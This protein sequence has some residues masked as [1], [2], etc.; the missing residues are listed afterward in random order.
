MAG[1]NVQ[2][3]F[4]RVANIQSVAVTAGNTSSEGGGTV[5]TSIFLA[6]TPGSNDSYVDFMRWM[7][8]ASAAAT[9]TTATV[10]RIFLSTVSTGTT[11][12]ANTFLIGEVP[13]PQVSAD[14]SSVANNAVDFALGFRIPGSLAT[15]PMFLM[16]TNH[17]APAATTQWLATTF[18]ADY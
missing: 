18:G 11:T 9:N 8:T 1:P 17:V 13:L 5:A 12:S 2:P 14:S 16:V 4:T 10:G 6:Y 7:P 15:L 3:T